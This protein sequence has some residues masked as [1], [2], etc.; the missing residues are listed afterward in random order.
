MRTISCVT[1][2]SD[3]CDRAVYRLRLTVQCPECG[4][5]TR[6]LET[7][8][9]QLQKRRRR[10][11]T[12]ATCGA[13][14][15]TLERIITPDKDLPLVVKNDGRSEAFAEHKLGR[16]LRLALAK[17][18]FDSHAVAAL[19]QEIRTQI[20]KRNA[21]EIPTKAIGQIVMCALCSSVTR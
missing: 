19:E 21:I 10:A 2:E 9:S 15:Q 14:F 6:V 16:S 7:R 17:R 20:L 13:R 8:Y 1:L 11:C 12:N 5:Q 3:A 18:P 4:A